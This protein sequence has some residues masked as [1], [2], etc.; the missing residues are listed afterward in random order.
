MP[1]AFRFGRLGETLRVVRGEALAAVAGQEED[2]GWRFHPGEKQKDLGTP[3]D[4][5]IGT[6][7]GNAEAILRYAR[8]SGDRRFLEA[9]L[10]ALAYMDRFRVPAGAQVWECPVH[11][12]D[13]YASAR[14]VRAY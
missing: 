1:L 5:T 11:A 6:C 2:G 13:I 8:L 14:A 7:A 10:K 12:P 9:G 4:T 3:G